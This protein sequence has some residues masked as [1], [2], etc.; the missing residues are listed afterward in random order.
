MLGDD[1]GM[2]IKL[3]LKDGSQYDWHVARPQGLLRKFAAHSG[4][5]RRLL[6]NLRTSPETLADIIHYIDDVSAG[7]LLAPVH[8]RTFTTYRYTFKQFGR[9]L[10]SCQ[11]CW[12]EY[13]ILR[14]SIVNEVVGGPSYVVRMLMHAFF[15]EAENFTTTSAWR[16]RVG[17]C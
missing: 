11:Q 17:F 12:I 2:V 8:G 15:T 13:G 10:L 1:V 9:H 6:R 14:V 16:T 5:L 4:A 3:P 7:H